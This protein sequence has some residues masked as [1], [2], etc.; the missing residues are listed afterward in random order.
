MKKEE[1]MLAMAD[2]ARI[3]LAVFSPEG[4]GEP[5]GAVLLVHGFGEHAGRYGQVAEFFAEKG[6]TLYAHDQRGHGRTP[7]RRGVVR[8]YGALLDDVSE[9]LGVIRREHPGV[10]VVLY[11]HSMGGNVA[12]NYLIGRDT[13]GIRCAVIGSPWLRLHTPV[14]KALELV[15]CRAS[16]MLP[17][18]SVRAKLA[19]PMLTHDEKIVE[20]TAHDPLY[21]NVMGGRL[22]EGVEAAGENA[23]RNASKITV[24]VLLMAAGDDHIVSLDA[25]REF[26][27]KAGDNVTFFEWP[28]AYHELHNEP[29]RLKILEYAWR[30]IARHIEKEGCL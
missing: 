4:P 22:L 8:S 13:E 24:P 15:V 12:L 9:V 26:A 14:P 18:L 5:R 23:V 29:E 7:G 16:R 25:E 27:R 2:G 6:L 11:G 17:A 21:H 3:H 30:F 1:R 20:R 28:G 19:L 10:P